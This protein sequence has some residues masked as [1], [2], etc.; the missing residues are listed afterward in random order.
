MMVPEEGL[1]VAGRELS[2]GLFGPRVAVRQLM[3]VGQEYLTDGV[4]LVA[5]V[6]DR[7]EQAAA[8]V[9]R[10]SDRLQV[11][12]FPGPLHHERAKEAGQLDVP[13]LHVPLTGEALYV[14]LMRAHRAGVDIERISIDSLS[15]AD[16]TEAY[17]EL[18]MSTDHVAVM[19]Y[20]RAADA[21]D[22]LQ[23][24]RDGL[25]HRRTVLALTTFYDVQQQLGDTGL[26]VQRMRPTRSTVRQTLTTA[27]L[28]ARGSRLH[29]TQIAMLAVQVPP[30]GSGTLEGPSHYWQQDVALSVQRLLLDEVR[31]SGAILQ[32]RSESRF[33]ITTT[34][35]GLEE[36]TADLTAAPFLS[37]CRDQ[38]GLDL[39]VGA[40]LGTTAQEAERHALAAMESAAAA[41]TG[42]HAALVDVDGSER[43]L[44]RTD[45]DPAPPG[46]DQRSGEILRTLINGRRGAGDTDQSELTVGVDD[47]A[48]I[49][50]V[51][52]RSARRICKMLIDAGLAW[53][54]QAVR[55]SSGGRPRQQFRLL[56]DKLPP[57]S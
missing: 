31:R 35:G 28:L 1:G 53:P 47:V 27:L 9:A 37:R 52:P 51:T 12:V 3:Q 6:L 54:T 15:L 21:G 49:L 50:A 45:S 19:P 43:L 34:R 4:R 25:E 56:A 5:A 8:E 22:Y 55:S 44:P 38:L 16:V 40:G 36:I 32:P 14:A 41:R 11:A 24:H 10:L 30:T 2:I 20:D 7:P 39:W 23:F 42:D 18:D 48:Q 46:A 17:T 29:Q 57:L 13:S 33:M 26:A